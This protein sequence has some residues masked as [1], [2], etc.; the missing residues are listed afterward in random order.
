[1]EK[2]LKVADMRA[3]EK[4]VNLGEISYSKMIEIINQKFTNTNDSEEFSEWIRMN[5][6]VEDFEFDIPHLKIKTIHADELYRLFLKAKNKTWGTLLNH[7][8]PLI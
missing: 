6:Y 7:E 2:L 3:L 4:Q 1:M 5:C 8:K